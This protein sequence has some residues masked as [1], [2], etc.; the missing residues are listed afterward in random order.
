MI[1]YPVVLAKEEVARR[2]RSD[3]GMEGESLGSLLF[4]RVP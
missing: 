3:G 4:S 1:V 2:R